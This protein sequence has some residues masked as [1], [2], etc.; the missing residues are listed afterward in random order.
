MDVFSLLL[1]QVLR[2]D[3]ACAW[4]AENRLGALSGFESFDDCKIEN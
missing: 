2:S 1:A 4:T 3:R